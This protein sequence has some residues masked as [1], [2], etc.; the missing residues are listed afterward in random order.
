MSMIIPRVGSYDTAKGLNKSLK[1]SLMENFIFC[2]VYILW[3]IKYYSFIHF[4]VNKRYLKIFKKS[5]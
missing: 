1:K 5:L 4:N 3:V 2:A